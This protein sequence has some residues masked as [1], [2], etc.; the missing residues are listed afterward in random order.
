MAEALAGIGILG[1]PKHKETGNRS[2]NEMLNYHH[3]APRQQD[4]QPP[5]VRCCQV[6]LRRLWQEAQG[7]QQGAFISHH[8]N[9]AKLELYSTRLLGEIR[10]NNY[11]PSLFKSE[12]VNADIIGGLVVE[13]GERTIDLSVSSKIAKMNKLLSEAL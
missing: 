11:L 4:P 6:P 7:H 10:Q 13:I 2:A 3:I 12:Q 9:P 5:R 1:E 8:P